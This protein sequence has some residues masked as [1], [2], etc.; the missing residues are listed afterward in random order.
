MTN[1]VKSSKRLLHPASLALGFFLLLTSALQSQTLTPVDYQPNL[2]IDYINDYRSKVN[3]PPFEWEPRLDSSSELHSQY[4]FVANGG[5]LSHNQDN[6]S[7]PLF[8]GRDPQ[9]RILRVYPQARAMG[10]VVGLTGNGKWQKI[11]DDLFDAPLHRIVLFERFQRAGAGVKRG[12]SGKQ[13]SLIGTVN[14]ADFDDSVGEDHSVAWPY[15]GQEGVAI[16]WFAN[17]MPSPIPLRYLGRRTGYP[18]SLQFGKSVR[19]SN[20]HINLSAINSNRTDIHSEQT[21]FLNYSSDPDHYRQNQNFVVFV[22]NRPLLANQTYRM[23]VT[24]VA[25]G[26]VMI[27]S[28]EFKTLAIEPLRVIVSPDKSEYSRGEIINLRIAGGTGTYHNEKNSTYRV[29]YS[30]GSD[31]RGVPV[32]VKPVSDSEYQLVNQCSSVRNCKI[33]LEFYDSASSVKQELNFVWY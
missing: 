30:Y 15:D 28:W 16:D 11:I 26:K 6:P 29:S 33:Q 31:Q 14:F 20:L 10:E 18:I 5:K 23:V 22:P 17:E 25:N 13:L 4:L 19:L 21:G 7:S 9:A 24:G 27:K 12:Y 8:R 2:V 3:L 1:I 32:V